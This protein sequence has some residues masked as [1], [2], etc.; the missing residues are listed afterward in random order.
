MKKPKVEKT[1]TANTNCAH[2]LYDAPI[3]ADKESASNMQDAAQANLDRF[4]F[5]QDKFVMRPRPNGRET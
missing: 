5:N 2:D 1:V 3:F 4:G